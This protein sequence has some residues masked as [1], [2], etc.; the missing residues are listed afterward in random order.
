MVVTEMNLASSTQSV[1]AAFDAFS[2]NGPSAGANVAHIDSVDILNSA[3][4]MQALEKGDSEFGCDD[5]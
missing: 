5:I 2:R 4:G 1:R 3:D